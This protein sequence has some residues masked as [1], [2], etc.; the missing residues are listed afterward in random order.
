MGGVKVA[1]M[2][3]MLN[4]TGNRSKVIWLTTVEAENNVRCFKEDRPVVAVVKDGKPVAGLE[5]VFK[6]IAEKSANYLGI[7]PSVPVKSMSEQKPR[8]V[9]R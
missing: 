6:V 1:A 9:S 4:V 2:E 7:E 3:R 8:V 5:K